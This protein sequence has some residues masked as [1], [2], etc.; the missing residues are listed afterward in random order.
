MSVGGGQ[1]AYCPVKAHRH[2]GMKSAKACLLPKGLI[3]EAA[4]LVGLAQEQGSGTSAK[5]THWGHC[6]HSMGGAG[7]GVQDQAPPASLRSSHS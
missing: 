4:S 2:S 6:I 5:L 3:T 1:Q 7:M